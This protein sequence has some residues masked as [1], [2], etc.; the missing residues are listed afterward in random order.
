MAVVALLRMRLGPEGLEQSSEGCVLLPGVMTF[1]AFFGG[2]DRAR[3]LG[4]HHW[5]I[6]SPFL[7]S[8]VFALAKTFVSSLALL[9]SG[10]CTLIGYG[11]LCISRSNVGVGGTGA[12][13]WCGLRGM[14]WH[15]WHASKSLGKFSI[16]CLCAG[17]QSKEVH[18]LFK[19]RVLISYNL[20]VSPT[21]FQIS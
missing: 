3:R 15:S 12:G 21:S 20:L 5:D 17:T 6:S 9:L 8:L 14:L 13:A 2:R 10:M 7:V 19:C 18:V 16:F 4:Q 11:N 1:S